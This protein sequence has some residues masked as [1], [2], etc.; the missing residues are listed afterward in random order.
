MALRP[1]RIGSGATICLRAI[2]APGADI[3][4]GACLGPLCSSHDVSASPSVASGAERALCS[5]EFP[6]PELP[7]QLVGY[8]AMFA[9]WAVTELP[10]AL[11]LVYISL[12]GHLMP[13]YAAALDWFVSTERITCLVALHVSREVI[14]PLIRVAC[15]VVVKRAIIGRFEAGPRARSQ[16]TLFQHWLMRELLPSEKLQVSRTG[17][18]HVYCLLYNHLLDCSGAAVLR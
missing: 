3:A 1:V 7:L 2:V 16:F 6:R 4:P 8:I 17:A 15:C 11:L 5:A 13:D 12:T 10:I 9:V 14:C 18:R